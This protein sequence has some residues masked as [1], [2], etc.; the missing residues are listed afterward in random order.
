MEKIREQSTW[1]FGSHSLWL[2]K[3]WCPRWGWDTKS[4]WESSLEGDE[5][6]VPQEVWM[7]QGKAASYILLQSCGWPWGV[8]LGKQEVAE[9]M[10]AAFLVLWWCVA[11]GW[12]WGIH[13]CFQGWSSG[14]HGLGWV[15][16]SSQVEV[17]CPIW[18]L[19]HREEMG[20]GGHG[21]MVCGSH[22]IHGWRLGRQAAAGV[23]LQPW[24]LPWELGWETET[25]EKVPPWAAYLVPCLLSSFSCHWTECLLEVEV[26][27]QQRGKSQG[28]VL[29]STGGVDSG[30]GKLQL[31]FC[32]NTRNH[33]ENW[34]EGNKE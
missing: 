6:W 28:E 7:G 31:M 3:W 2:S 22:Q 11:C 19:G 29:R 34:V 27:T 21:G 5:P 24:G 14:M 25:M 8:G 13:L 16:V 17:T 33:S 15:G 18:G 12:A 32:C 20:R 26:G 1:S 10:L 30:E 23:L 4:K 9:H